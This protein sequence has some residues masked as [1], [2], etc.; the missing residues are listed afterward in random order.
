VVTEDD[1]LGF[2]TGLAGGWTAFVAAIVV[3]LTVLGAL[4][5]WAI[6][7][8]VPVFLV[9]W[10]LRRRRPAPAP[11]AATPTPSPEP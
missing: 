2:L 10:W 5:P 7:I 11:P 6:A 9:V 3:A 4:L 1:H 8:G